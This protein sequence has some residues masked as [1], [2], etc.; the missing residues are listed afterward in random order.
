MTRR[1]GG[2][3]THFGTKYTLGI[4][5]YVILFKYDYPYFTG[6]ETEI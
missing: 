1:R 6:K 2:W 3:L 5:I 4:L